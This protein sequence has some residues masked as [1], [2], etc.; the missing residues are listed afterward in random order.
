[1]SENGDFTRVIDI[2]LI[3]LWITMDSIVDNNTV[4]HK[5]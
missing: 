1:M 5:L 4:I 2:M 3:S